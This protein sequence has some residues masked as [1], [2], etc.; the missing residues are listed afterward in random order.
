[1][2]KEWITKVS[3]SVVSSSLGITALDSRKSKI[4]DLYSDHTENKLQALTFATITFVCSSLQCF[5]LA[6]NVHHGVVNQLRYSVSPV[7]T[8]AYG[9]EGGLV[10]EM[11]P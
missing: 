2:S 8:Y 1:M 4:L 11:T 7:V 3:A 9:Y 10:E 6:K 5:N